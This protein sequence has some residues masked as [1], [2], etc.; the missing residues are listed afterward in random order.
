MRSI[1]RFT[2]PL[3]IGSLCTA[4]LALGCAGLGCLCG[5]LTS[6]ALFEI[7]LAGYFGAPEEEGG[8]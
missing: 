4:V 5:S 6:T 2:W 3:M 1:E 8:D 7:L